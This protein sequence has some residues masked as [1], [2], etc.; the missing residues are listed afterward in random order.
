M[1]RGPKDIQVSMFL[2]ADTVKMM[3][4]VRDSFED[5]VS[6]AEVVEMAFSHLTENEKC[7]VETFGP[8]EDDDEDGDGA[9]EDIAADDPEAP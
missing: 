9:E 5:S 6:R 2:D 7:L 3:D 8:D 1:S 4:A